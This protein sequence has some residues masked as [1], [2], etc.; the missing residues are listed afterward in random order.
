MT[1]DLSEAGT[2]YPS[3]ASVLLIIL[4]VYILSYVVSLSSELRVVRPVTISAYGFFL[5]EGCCCVEQKSK[6]KRY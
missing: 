1:G 4:V 5:G 6:G 3:V 2:A